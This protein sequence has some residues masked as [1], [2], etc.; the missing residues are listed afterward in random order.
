MIRF[1]PICFAESTPSSPTAPSPTT[2]TV[3]PGLTFAA[4][5]ANHPV[6]MTSDNVN[7]LG[8]RSSEG[9]SD[10]ATRVPSASGTELALDARGL[11]TVLADYARVVRG[12]KR[13][14]HE[15]A[16]LDFPHLSTD[17]FNYAAILVTHRCRLRDRLN[18]TIRPQIRSADAG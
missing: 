8:M 10:V 13:A 4:S 1:A 2:A 5:A 16:G 9:I 6:P 17:L 3:E 11:I 18:A 7:R 12:C 15:L 14:D